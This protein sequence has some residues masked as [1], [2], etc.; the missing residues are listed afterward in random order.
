MTLLLT[1]AEVETFKSRGFLGPFT[2]MPEDEAVALGRRLVDE[3]T[4]TPSPFYAHTKA[5]IPKL[6]FI[7]DRHWDSPAVARILS[8]GRIVQRITR[9]LGPDVLLWRSDFFVQGREDRETAPHQDMA[10]SGMR[11]I[12]AL[13]MADGRMPLNISAWISFTPV[14]REH[15]GL[16]VVPGT[17]HEVLREVPADPANSIF[18]KGRVLE[19]NFT[20]QDRFELKMRPGQFLLFTNLLVHGSYKTAVER[21]RIALSG[22]FIGPDVIVNPQGTEVSGHGM[23]LSRYGVT[24]VAGSLRSAPT[25]LRALACGNGSGSISEERM[26]L[27]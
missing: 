24:L 13:A 1:D 5:D 18:G 10:F 26:L 22:R 16:F 4:T 3:V 14:D 11:K 8:D 25:P 7:R 23:D 27:G 9:L 17:H 12:P 2:V 19:K 21:E 20:E 6:N 15:G